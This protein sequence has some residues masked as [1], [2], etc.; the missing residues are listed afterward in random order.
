MERNFTVGLYRLHFK[1][2]QF[3]FDLQ[4]ENFLQQQNSVV[5]HT[6]TL[7][8]EYFLAKT[9]LCFL[10]TMIILITFGSRRS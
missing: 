4:F 10:N 8:F 9:R 1:R 6:I 3:A 2:L 7:Q 5:T